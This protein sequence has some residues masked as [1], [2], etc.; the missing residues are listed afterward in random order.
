MLRVLPHTHCLG[1]QLQNRSKAQICQA[2][3]QEVGVRSKKDWLGQHLFVGRQRNT[4]GAWCGQVVEAAGS[5]RVRIWRLSRVS[6]ISM[7]MAG[8][9]QGMASAGSV[10]GARS[11]LARGCATGS[12][13]S[14]CLARFCFERSQKWDRAAA[15]F[16]GPFWHPLFSK[17]NILWRSCF[18]GRLAVSVLEPPCGQLSVFLAG[19]AGVNETSSGLHFFGVQGAA[20][21]LRAH[22]PVGNVPLSAG[23]WTSGFSRHC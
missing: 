15:P 3:L 1:L 14:A 10:K 16:L 21:W 20:L 6:D 22:Q 7:Q 9:L 13:A 4:L 23:A 12:A 19:A 5:L 8:Q 11:I 18:W 2:T 17:S